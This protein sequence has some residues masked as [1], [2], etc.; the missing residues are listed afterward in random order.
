[1]LRAVLLSSSTM[2]L[3][4]LFL[5]AALPIILV[6]LGS[7]CAAMFND[8]SPVIPV[9]VSP[10]GARVYVDGL[11]VAQAPTQIRLN[12]ANPHMVQVAA[13]GY[14]PQTIHI[15]PHTSGGYI[16]LDCL[17]LLALI[18]PGIIALAVDGGSGY[19]KVFDFD[20][21]TVQLQPLGARPPPPPPSPL[22]P[23]ASFPPSAPAP[24][25]APSTY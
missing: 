21:L 14:E 24:G 18:V 25:P 13:E 9:Q 7:G 15:H 2:T 19:W 23:P 17:L 16:V 12:T 11:Y 4:G 6:N 5:G 22:P 3:R 8:Q 1:M 10:P 20:Q